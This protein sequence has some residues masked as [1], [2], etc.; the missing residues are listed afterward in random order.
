MYSLT[1]KCEG[2]TSVDPL[3]DLEL[4]VVLQGVDAK[5]FVKHNESVI[6]HLLEE[7]EEDED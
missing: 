3:A 1:V 4:L 6:K 7:Q 2:L 5:S